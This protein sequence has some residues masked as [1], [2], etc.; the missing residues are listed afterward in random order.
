MLWLEINHDV[1]YSLFVAPSFWVLW[2]GLSF[3][4]GWKKMKNELFFHSPFGSKLSDKSLGFWICQKSWR[5]LPLLLDYIF[6][7]WFQKCTKPDVFGQ[8][9]QYLWPARRWS[10]GL[11]NQ[12]N[13]KPSSSDPRPKDWQKTRNYNLCLVLVFIIFHSIWRVWLLVGGLI[14][15]LL[16]V[17]MSFLSP[18]ANLA[19]PVFSFFCFFT[20][21]ILGL[22]LICF[23]SSSSL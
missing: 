23:P 22:C 14:W 21:T 19:E 5:S 18:R 12:S 20:G 2:R 13:L 11:P 6:F 15:V 8:N 9:L 4:E 17:V 7:F 1:C 16:S 10:S 3:W